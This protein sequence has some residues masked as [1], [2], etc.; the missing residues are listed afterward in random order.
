MRLRFNGAQRGLALIVTSAGL[1]LYSAELH[2]LPAN[3]VYA[4]MLSNGAVLVAVRIAAACCF[5]AGFMQLIMN[6]N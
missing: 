6:K 2:S 4:L 3:E 5:V 1:M